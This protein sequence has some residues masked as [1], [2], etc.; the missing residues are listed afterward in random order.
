LRASASAEQIEAKKTELLNQLSTDI[1]S[2]PQSRSHLLSGKQGVGIHAPAQLEAAKALD[3]RF[4]TALAGDRRAPEQFQGSIQAAVPPPPQTRE[5]D[6]A[7]MVRRRTA[8]A[9]KA[10]PSQHQEPP[11]A[12]SSQEIHA[13]MPVRQSQLPTINSADE[14]NSET[15]EQITYLSQAKNGLKQLVDAI[16]NR[17]DANRDRL[18]RQFTVKSGLQFN[19]AH[20][21]TVIENALKRVRDF[22]ATTTG[23]YQALQEIQIG[24]TA[25]NNKLQEVINLHS[26]RR[27]QTPHLS[28]GTPAQE[29]VQSLSSR[30]QS[31]T[32]ALRGVTP[33][34][35]T[36][37]CLQSQ[38]PNQGHSPSHRY[39]HRS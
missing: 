11:G 8:Q 25:S 2:K 24:L 28:Q 18:W 32:P 14:Q 1:G 35:L 38:P 27:A 33:A 12:S 37:R 4:R 23:Q 6:F 26:S 9:R 20:V 3:K 39:N 10:D 29:R 17:D 15:S 13:P 16:V 21:K 5:E 34:E 36:R 22:P 30:S 19:V 7:A 31:T